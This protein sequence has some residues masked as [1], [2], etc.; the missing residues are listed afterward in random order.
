MVILCVFSFFTFILDIWRGGFLLGCG[1]CKDGHTVLRT[2]L[3]GHL[4]CEGSDGMIIVRQ[5]IRIDAFCWVLPLRDFIGGLGLG[6]QGLGEG[7]GYGYGY[8]Y[9]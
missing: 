4:V 8:G 1:G 6:V 3:L 2:L 9:G 7:G 5:V